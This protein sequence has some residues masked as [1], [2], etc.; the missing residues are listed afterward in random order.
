ML[1]QINKITN[2]LDATLQKVNVMGENINKM[3]MSFSQEIVSLTENIRLIV[4]VL[5]Q[6]R[7]KSAETLTKIAEDVNKE[8]KELWEKESVKH[9]TEQHQQNIDTIKRVSASVTDTLYYTQ[10]LSVV[11]SIREIMG[12]ALKGK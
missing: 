4:E 6:G 9:M 10:L 3:T 5:R 12:R 7:V 2:S 8:V 11:Q 1:E